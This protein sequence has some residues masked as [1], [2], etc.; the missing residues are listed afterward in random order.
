SSDRH[1]LAAGDCTRFIHPFNGQTL[2]LESVQNA[3][4]QARTAA[5][6]ITG[7]NRPYDVVPW[8]WSDQYEIKLQMVGLSQ[9]CDARILRGEMA[10]N[11]FSLYHFNGERL[12]AIDC[13]NR[14]GEAIL[15]R[16]L[17]AAGLSP[18]REQA[19]DPGFDLKSLM[20]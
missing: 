7:K 8:F 13:I 17:L 5:S 14:P 3:I 19:A 16:R 4:D 20:P 12:R 6:T 10:G 1:I 2:R 9:G 11:A 15:G 18:T